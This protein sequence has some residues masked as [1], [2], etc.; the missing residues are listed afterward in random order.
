V[1]LVRLVVLAPGVV[2]LHQPLQGFGQ[3][4]LARCGYRCFPLLQTFVALQKQGLGVGILLLF[5]WGAAVWG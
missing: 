2:E 3:P 1:P 5:N 4:G